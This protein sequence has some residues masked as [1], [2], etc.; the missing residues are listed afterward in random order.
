MFLF[1]FTDGV[2]I[3][4][5][6]NSISA[7]QRLRNRKIQPT[8]MRL[9]VLNFLADS[10]AA[11]GL[12]DLEEYFTRADRTTLYRTLKTFLEQG[13]VHQINDASGTAKYALCAENCTCSYPDD[14]HLHFY[15]ASCEQTFCFTHLGIPPFEL[16]EGFTPSHANFV[17]T[18]KCP[19]CAS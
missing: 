5:T 15:C 12:N 17:I 9:R 16:P 1:M 2:F 11:V 4:S 19:V 8:A 13:L 14:I 7:E 18:G 3:L 10:Q 6:M